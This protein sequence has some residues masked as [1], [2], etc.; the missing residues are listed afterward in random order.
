[1]ALPL[2][3]TALPS[4][5]DLSAGPV[6]VTI[7]SPDSV[8]LKYTLDGT[9]PTIDS[10]GS[11]IYSVSGSGIINIPSDHTLVYAI[12]IS[13][14]I[15]SDV[16]KFQYDTEVEVVLHPDKESY[17]YGETVTA[18]LNSIS[19]GTIQTYEDYRWINEQKQNRFDQAEDDDTFLGPRPT[20]TLNKIGNYRVRV[21]F[22]DHGFA[23]IRTRNLFKVYPVLNIKYKGLEEDQ[24]DAPVVED[25]RN[26]STPLLGNNT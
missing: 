10:E 9:V 20:F 23:P 17:T 24:V 8:D 5:R 19:D 14:G 11:N 26:V 1:M 6:A 21:A 22:K 7:T 12:A 25:E 18:T 3:P 4:T 2:P 13:G 16:S 15:V